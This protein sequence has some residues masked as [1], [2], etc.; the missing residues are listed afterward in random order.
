MDPDNLNTENPGSGHNYSD[1]TPCSGMPYN[2][3]HQYLVSTYNQLRQRG[4]WVTMDTNQM[5]IYVYQF[6]APGIENENK[7]QGIKSSLKLEVSE[8]PFSVQTII[9]VFGDVSDDTDIKIYDTKG[10]LVKNLPFQKES[11]SFSTTWDGKDKYK[12][13]VAQGVYFYTLE[14]SKQTFTKKLVLMK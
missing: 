4:H 13:A 12:R 10:A 5:N 11:N 14:T 3:F 7:S 2:A 8:N 6:S 1:G 9:R